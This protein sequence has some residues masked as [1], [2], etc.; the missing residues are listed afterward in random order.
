M[1]REDQRQ[2]VLRAER[3]ARARRLRP[4]GER[5]EL[6]VADGLAVRHA[7]QRLRDRP[8]QRRAPLEVDLDVV[9]RDALAGEVRLEN[10]MP[11]GQPLRDC[12]DAPRARSSAARARPGA[13]RRRATAPPRPS[14][15]RRSARPASP[16]T[17]QSPSWPPT[18]SSRPRRRSTSRSRTTRRLARARVAEAP[19]RRDGGR[20]PR[21]PVRDRRQGGAHRRPRPGGDAAPQEPRA[22]RRPPGR[23]GRGAAGD[24]GVRRR[25]AGLG[26]DAVG[27][28]RRRPPARRRAARRPVAHDA[29]RRDDAQPVEDGAPGR[30]RRRRR[31]DRLLPLQRRVHD[32]DLRGAAD[33]VAGRLEPAGVPAARG[34]RLR[35][36]PV[37][38]HGDRRQPDDLGGADGQ[39]R[40]LEAR[41][42]RRAL[43]LLH[44]EALASRRAC[45]TA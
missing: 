25:L 26:P 13:R 28:A 21:H 19:A 10:D 44:V 42:D 29:R 27:G 41:L 34:L 43:R 45:R 7:P 5:G 31:A 36:Q 40:A 24:Q 20:A 11:G 14:P 32:A 17:I 8:L 4:A 1:A 18:E 30:D 37:Q 33:L 6:A 35:R 22:R 2:P 39:H 3:P 23:R 15:R 38:L 16:S 12:P 9:E